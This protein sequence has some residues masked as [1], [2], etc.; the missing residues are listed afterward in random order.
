[1]DEGGASL[2]DRLTDIGLD[3]KEASVIILLATSEPLKASAV[4]RM[5]GIS[6]MDSYNTLKRL[7]ERGLVMSTL[8]K[9]MRFTGLEIEEIFQQLI[10]HEEQE[11]RRI[12]THLDEFQK[13]QKRTYRPE[14]PPQK[15]AIFTVVKERSYIHAAMERVIDDSETSVWLV[16]G[17]YGILHLVKT[18]A[19]RASNDA[20][21]R[22]VSVRVL[23]SLD[24]TTL[25]YFE[26]LDERIE[27]RHSD[28]ISMHGC[29]I[30]GEVAVQNVAIEKNPV[31]RGKEDAAL[32]IE[33]PSFLST[34]TE[35]I[36]SAWNNATPISTAKV[37]VERGENTQP[38]H[39]NLGAGSFYRRFKEI[40]A[41]NVED[42]HPDNHGWT[43]AILRHGEPILTPQPNLPE[44]ELLG[45][46]VADLMRIVGKRIGEE[47]AF[48]IDNNA[49]SDVEFWDLLSEEWKEMEMGE[50][51]IIGDPPASIIVHDAGACGKA[52]QFGS[53]FCHLDEGILEGIIGEKFGIGKIAVE[54]TCSDEGKTPCFFEILFDQLD[55]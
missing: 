47:I 49:S 26:Q 17:K 43:N 37:L 32:V 15:D 40:I 41:R 39:I 8:D 50:M 16:L 33:A 21:D 18:G 23:A 42:Q 46:N 20:V 34:Q 1:M 4:G 10:N 55:T 25:K 53:P 9:P 28:S 6:R 51:E 2:N 19:L 38:L 54:R 11:L 3:E 14:N 24:K 7:Q 48:E 12:R 30:D 52:P 36:E 35:L 27:I 44:F 45:L 22:G 5:V 29:I 13:G 31:G